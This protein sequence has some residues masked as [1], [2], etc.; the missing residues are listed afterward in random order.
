MIGGVFSQAR[1]PVDGLIPTTV[2]FHHERGLGFR[3]IAEAIF[4]INDAATRASEEVFERLIAPA[5]DLSPETI[6]QVLWQIREHGNDAFALESASHGSTRFDGPL[7][8]VVFFIGGI[9]SDQTLEHSRHFDDWMTTAGHAAD[10][11]IDKATEIGETALDEIKAII[12]LR[13]NSESALGR[14]DGSHYDVVVDG[15][16]L[17]IEVYPCGLKTDNAN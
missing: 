8:S 16:R 10:S 3:A 13:L 6:D 11:A 15:D 1:I 5:Y 4:V 9:L 7:W 14:K 12:A 17:R 2:T